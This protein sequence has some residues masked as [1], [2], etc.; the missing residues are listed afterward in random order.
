ML[1]TIG[2]ILVVLWLLGLLTSVTL[3]GFIHA[4]LVIGIILACI[5]VVVFFAANAY[6]LGRE[7]F[8][9]AALRFRPAAEASRTES[10]AA[11][12]S[13]KRAMMSSE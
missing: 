11:I 2:I 10:P 6:L 4:L 5:A 1:M 13:L 8:E 7:Y 12:C 3:G 9:L